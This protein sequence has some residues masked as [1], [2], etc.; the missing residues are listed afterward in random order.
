MK[1]FIY[2][3]SFL[4][5]LTSC[6]E[7]D[8][9]T[10]NET[11]SSELTTMLVNATTGLRIGQFIEDGVDETNMFLGFVFYFNADGS[12]VASKQGQN[13]IIGSFLA[14]EDD[15][16]TE[17][18]MSFPTNSTLFELNDDWYF[19]SESQGRISFDDS[20]DSLVLEP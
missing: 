13:D 7:S 12:V 17:L 20:G 2:L 6:D 15:G 5:F 10:S 16:K 11:S 18:R 4:F 14:F 8:G 3:L 1:N 9:S 19:V